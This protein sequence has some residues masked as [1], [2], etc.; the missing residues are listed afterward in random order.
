MFCVSAV[1]KITGGIPGD[2]AE[3]GVPLQ[4][5]TLHHTRQHPDPGPG[6]GGAKGDGGCRE[7]RGHRPSS[8]IRARSRRARL[9]SSTRHRGGKGPAH[10]H[11]HVLYM[12]S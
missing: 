4:H 12:Y 6:D 8:E 10:Q 1:K 3:H 11:K 7:R 9:G 2:Q 5:K